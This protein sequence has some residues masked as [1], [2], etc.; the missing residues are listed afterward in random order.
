MNP[1]KQTRTWVILC[2][3]VLVL[4]P[5]HGLTQQSSDASKSSAQPTPARDG[6]RDF[7]P[8]LGSWKYHLKRRLNPLTGS[9]TWVE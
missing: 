8:L 1:L 5:L 4:L 7:D 3:L 9:N 2:D 6:S